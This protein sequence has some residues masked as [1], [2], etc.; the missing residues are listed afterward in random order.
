MAVLSLAMLFWAG[1]LTPQFWQLALVTLPVSA[2]AAW[3][4]VR[5]YMRL[6]E[7]QFQGLVMAILGA[8]GLSIL[9]SLFFS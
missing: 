5:I 7:A 8:S 3:V 9:A 6:G 1:Y 2:A 4:G